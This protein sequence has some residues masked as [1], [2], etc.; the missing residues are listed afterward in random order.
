MLDSTFLL[1][2]GGYAGVYHWADYSLAVGNIHLPTNLPNARYTLPKN[3]RAFDLRRPEEP[4]LRRV[5]KTTPSF[6]AVAAAAAFW[7]D[8]LFEEEEEERSRFGFAF[9]TNHRVIKP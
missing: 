2:S 9:P 7:H 6:S 3:D 1:Q 4:T 5:R 8:K